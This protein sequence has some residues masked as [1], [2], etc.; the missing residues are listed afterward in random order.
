[1]TENEARQALLLQAHEAAETDRH[2]SADDR[3]WATREALAQ[4]GDKAAPERFVAVRAALAL[5]RLLPRDAS[6]DRWLKRRAWHEAWVWGGAL[7]GFVAG[8]LTDQLG[9]PAHVNLLAP[10]VWAVV[11]WNLCVYVGALLPWRG[12]VGSQLGP[13]FARR[14]RGADLAATLLWVQHATPLAKKRAALVLHTAAAGLALGLMASLYLRGLVL[15]YR[16]GWQST[17]LEAPAVQALLDTLLAPA[18]LLIGLPVPDVMPLR[19]APGEAA[20]ATAAPW[21]HLY[22]TTL[23]LWVVLPRLL[24]AAWSAARAGALSRRFPLQLDTP[25]F[26]SLHPLLRPDLSRTLRLMWVAPPGLAPVSLFGQP[27]GAEGSTLLRSE[28]GDELR[29]VPPSAAQESAAE[30]A[31]RW[32]N[33]WRQ[34]ASPAPERVDAVL[35]VN[36]P[37][38]PRPDW[39]PAL[40]KPVLVLHDADVA[41][42]PALPLRRLADGWLPEGRLLQSLAQLLPDDPRLA[43][44]ATAWTVRQQALLDAGVDEIARTLAHVASAK[45]PVAETGMLGGV[46]GEAEASREVARHALLASLDRELVEHR[47]RLLALLDRP[48]DDPAT[49]GPAGVPGAEVALRGRIGEGRAAVVGGLLSGAAAGFKAD[50]LSGGLTMGAGAL[51]GGLIGALGAAGAARSVNVLRGTDRTHVTWDEVALQAIA[52]ALLQRWAVLVTGLPPELA[53]ERLAPAVSVRDVEFARAWSLRG[54]ALD[55]GDQ[56]AAALREPLA[57]ALM[58]GLGGPAVPSARY[59]A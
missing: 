57:E 9:A 22:A 28:E 49:V 30:A 45:E 33:R 27:V 43:R 37:G 11:L 48:A 24:L 29:L 47:A 13:W 51:A 40:K 25:Y 4:V 21:I 35:L 41:E 3:A 23:M 19:V 8:L 54:P 20:Q 16:A 2:W 38:Q 39:L 34:P 6:A 50:L 15:D 46:R 17:F 18:S 31:P 56:V 59:R 52:A 53:L 14:G 42:P 55:A 32:W 12:G 10:A 36:G 1:M 58:Q 44:L 26:E 5:D 7:L